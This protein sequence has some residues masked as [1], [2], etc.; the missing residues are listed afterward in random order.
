MNYLYQHEE[1]D[2]RLDLVHLCLRLRNS[3]LMQNNSN[4]PILFWP[5]LYCEPEI[6]FKILGLSIDIKPSLKGMEAVNEI[7]S[8][9]HNNSFYT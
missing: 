3:I 5:K 8:H 2:V 4:H 9:C 6:F 7:Q 1:W